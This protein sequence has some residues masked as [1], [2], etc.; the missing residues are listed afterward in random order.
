MNVAD[1]ILIY[2]YI[3]L[4]NLPSRNLGFVF[5]DVFLLHVVELKCEKHSVT[6]LFYD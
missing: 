2:L 1:L 4:M 6:F 5:S 3:Y